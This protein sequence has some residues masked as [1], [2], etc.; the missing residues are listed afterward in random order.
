MKRK[1]IS[2]LLIFS[3]LFSVG[4]YST[5]LITKEEFKAKVKQDDIT[6]FMKN[7]LEY[8][9]LKDNYSIQGDTLSGFGVRKWS[10]GS[11][12]V[13]DASLPFTDITSIEAR[14]FNLTRTLI[15]CGGIG[16]PIIILFSPLSP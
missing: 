16:V 5:D 15:L 10:W 9:F 2:C 11:D 3:L 12:I 1:I 7:S 14:Q 8:K 13:L 6:L 4:C